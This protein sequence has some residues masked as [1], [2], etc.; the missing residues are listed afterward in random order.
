MGRL[1]ET[2]LQEKK[3]SGSMVTMTEEQRQALKTDVSRKR[4][5]PERAMLSRRIQSFRVA[6]ERKAF[7]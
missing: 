7:S 1:E 5:L 6:M 4:H 2:D 3:A